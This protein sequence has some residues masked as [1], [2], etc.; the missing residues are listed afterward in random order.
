MGTIGNAGPLVILGDI[1]FFGGG[2]TYLYAFDKRTGTEI[3]RGAPPFLTSENPMTYRTRSGQQFV[4]I[5]TGSEAD[6]ALVAF[7]R[8][9]Q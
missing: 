8:S 3:W 5:G 6:A 7:A 2:D 1:V 9:G 4:V